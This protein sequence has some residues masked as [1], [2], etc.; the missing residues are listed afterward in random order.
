MRKILFLFFLLI[1]I[2]AFATV[3][4]T[5][6]SIQ[7]TCAD[8]VGPY[9]FTFPISTLTDIQVVKTDSINISTILSSSL[10]TV[11]LTNGYSNGGTVTLKSAC[12]SGD[13]LT[14]KRDIPLK[15][16]SHFT[17]GMATLY[18]TFENVLDK[19]IMI[20]QQLQTNID[21]GVPGQQGA[22]GATGGSFGQNYQYIG[23][24]TDLA[25]AI[26]TI[27]STVTTLLVDTPQT[28]SG[29]IT[30]P[31]T[32]TLWLMN[33]TLIT[34]NTGKTI[35]INGSVIIPNSKVF[36]C[37][38]TGKV[39]FSNPSTVLYPEWW[40]AVGDGTVDDTIPLA[41]FFTAVKGKTGVL[42]GT[43]KTTATVTI[44]TSYTVIKGNGSPGV[45]STSSAPCIKYTGTGTGV[46][47]GVYVTPYTTWT[48]GI[49]FENIRVE[50]AAT[51]TTAVDVWGVANSKFDNISIYG[52]SGGSIGS[53]RYGLAI[54]GTVNCLFSK[55]D[56]N[57]TSNLYAGLYIRTGIG[58][59]ITTS[60]RFI[61]GYFHYCKYGVLQANTDI[62]SM[63]NC[64]FELN[65]TGIV[66]NGIIKLNNCHWESNIT[67]DIYFDR[68]S[69]VSI[70]GG[71]INSNTNLTPRTSGSYFGIGSDGDPQR[72]TLKNI[73]FGSTHAGPT[74]FLSGQAL[75]T[76]R[77]LIEQCTFPTAMTFGGASYDTWTSMKARIVD[78]PISV[79]RFRQSA[80]AISTTYST[81]PTE[82][83][84]DG[85]GYILPMK[86]HIL[87][88]RYWYSKTMGGGTIDLAILKNAGAVTRFTKMGATS[89]P[90]F[91][92]DV[93]FSSVV[94]AGDKL[95][96]YAKTDGSFA[97]TG[98]DLIIEVYV[99]HGEDGI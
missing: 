26:S 94:A 84:I 13:L 9:S 32:L 67:Q 98:G 14:I 68:Y 17:E 61:E 10:Y 5:T 80:V 58:G 50:V 91:W 77:V 8:S 90:V 70:D 36:N 89:L 42:T 82:S 4:T 29:D 62:F 47:I 22:Q 45:N 37:V 97:T 44:D 87:A 75:T 79:Y 40:G 16:T 53:P 69:E 23:N 30:I 73:H 18:K 31:S 78:M 72:I 41:S 95:T 99:E 86:G 6:D 20:D 57:G 66:T 64:V 43:Y 71:Y 85:T 48:Y 21:A 2:P 28:V 35:T 76:A 55:I 49:V 60:T 24:Y 92:A 88:V 19:L 33:P 65:D 38:G 1:A 39:V 46:E 15:Q 63:D 54:S 83:V 59:E 56:I 93:P 7:Y 51:T 12:A 81:I 25:T 11:S 27:G 74:L 34:V 3:T 96:A 52:N